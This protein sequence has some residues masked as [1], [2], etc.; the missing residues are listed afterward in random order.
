[1]KNRVD[2]YLLIVLFAAIGGGALWW[3]FGR[4]PA[5]VVYVVQ[6]GDTLSA[7]AGRYEV[8]VDELRG[9][10]G[11]TGDLIEIGQELVIAVGEPAEPVAGGPVA[12]GGGGW[13][14]GAA[15]LDV[16]AAPEDGAR[17][18]RLVP[19]TPEPCI[20]F[21]ADPGEEGMVAPNGLSFAQ[22]KAALDAVISEALYCPDAPTGA[23]QM[24]FSI[25]VGCDGVVDVVTPA[26]NVS[27]GFLGC[28]S[29]VIQHAD[30]PAHDIEGGQTFTYPVNATF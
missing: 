12:S 10:N 28:V 11:L 29:D 7:I 9:W 5:E 27:P 21:D 6:A 15:Q 4:G 8:T 20:P 24:S 14:G 16:S 26:G 25:T 19:P 22:T 23:V 17:R 3:K 18:P 1:V 2:L 13:T 30:F